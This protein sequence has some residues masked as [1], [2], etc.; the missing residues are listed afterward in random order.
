M[1]LGRELGKSEFEIAPDNS[2]TCTGESMCKTAHRTSNAECHRRR[3]PANY[4]Q[5]AEAVQTG[6]VFGAR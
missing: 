2:S 5:Q 4:A 1:F 6:H 3:Q